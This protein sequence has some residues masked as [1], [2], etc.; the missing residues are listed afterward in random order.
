MNLTISRIEKNQSLFPLGGD[1]VRK[2]TLLQKK[3]NTKS[4]NKEHVRFDH[5][6]WPIVPAFPTAE[7][8]TFLLSPST[9][10]V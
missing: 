5:E 2:A 8:S 7:C 9:T 6:V 4:A 1:G 3:T 10:C